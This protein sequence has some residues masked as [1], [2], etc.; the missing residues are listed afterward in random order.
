MSIPHIAVAGYSEFWDSNL[1]AYR[2]EVFA[3]DIAD[4]C[5]LYRREG[6]AAPVIRTPIDLRDAK[7]D[8]RW[9]REQASHTRA[10]A[11]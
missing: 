11:R 2:D 10:V 3:R 5:A 4:L 8:L 9:L 1:D 7:D 6:F